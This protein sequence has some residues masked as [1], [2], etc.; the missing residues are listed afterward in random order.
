MYQLLRRP[1]GR[2]WA[3]LGDW[4]ALDET[5]PIPA[6]RP[7]VLFMREDRSTLGL[8]ERQTF[9]V[10]GTC[11][12]ALSI[13]PA[14]KGFWL[15]PVFSLGA[16]ALLVFALDRHRQST[17]ASETLELGEGKVVLRRLRQAPVE[18]SLIRMRFAAEQRSPS[19]LRLFI[20]D[21]QRSIEIGSC[22]SLE[23]RQ[24]IAPLIASALA[25]VR[26]S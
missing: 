9:A 6:E 21:W 13:L 5:D 26:R 2:S 7:L 25:E 15:V 11:L 19:D 16:L 23:E 22:L 12:A 8:Y 17:P 10:I 4:L 3:T 18:L 20:R 14:L 24:A 1:E